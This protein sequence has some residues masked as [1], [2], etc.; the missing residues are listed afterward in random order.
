METKPRAYPTSMTER[1]PERGQLTRFMRLAS[2]QLQEE[3]LAFGW[4]ALR[5]ERIVALEYKLIARTRGMA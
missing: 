2:A 4:S 1:N 5:A 3:Q